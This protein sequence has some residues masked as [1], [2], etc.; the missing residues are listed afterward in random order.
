M[1]LGEL[2][3]RVVRRIDAHGTWEPARWLWPGDCGPF[4]RGVFHPESS[5]AKLFGYEVSVVNGGL[6]D[7]D[8][9]TAGVHRV[10]AQGSVGLATGLDD[11]MSVGGSLS[12]LTD[13]SENL[14]LLTRH[15]TWW[16][17]ADV[18]DVREQIRSHISTFP[19]TW[20]VVTRVLVATAAV[21]GLSS[22]STA[23]FTVSAEAG[24]PLRITPSANAV[25]GAAGSQAAVVHLALE[26]NLSPLPRGQVPS[27]D[28]AFT[29][30]FSGAYRI[31]K[32]FLGAA[33]RPEFVE[34]EY[35][36]SGVRW[37]NALMRLLL[38]R[39]RYLAEADVADVP[40]EDLFEELSPSAIE[41]ELDEVAADRVT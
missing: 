22:E 4:I 17:V 3:C 32:A 40:A 30:I 33:G 37:I 41:A 35:Q 38:P 29:P 16:E 18:Q 19:P 13:G 7:M 2:Y 5:L 20:I 27:S 8:F 9:V 10:R 12:Y 24:G 26:P 15:G 36:G 25:A 11:L 14:V 39:K 21:G 1:H 23:G 28:Y 31:R 34:A 6:S